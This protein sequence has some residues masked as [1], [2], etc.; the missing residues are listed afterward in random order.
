MPQT[1]EKVCSDLRIDKVLLDEL[2]YQSRQRYEKAANTNT[3]QQDIIPLS[4]VPN[5]K[6]ILDEP[7]RLLTR[8]L[9]DKLPFIVKGGQ[10]IT[11]G[12]AARIGDGAGLVILASERYIRKHNLQ[13]LVA[14]DSW[15]SMACHPSEMAKASSLAIQQL[16][17]KQSITSS[18]VDIIEHA[19]S[20]SLQSFLIHT[21]T[22]IDLNRINVHG[23]NLSSGNQFRLVLCVLLFE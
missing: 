13:P 8:S 21:H 5:P 16:M 10:F 23:S 3:H 22:G 20:F 17:M 2:A 14:I 19:E 12:N 11:L 7:H 15:T 1:A 6:P 9:M 4:T 18:N